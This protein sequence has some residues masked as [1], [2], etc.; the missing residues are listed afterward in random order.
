MATDQEI[1]NLRGELDR[2]KKILE[3]TNSSFS[4]YGNAIKSKTE[5]LNAQMRT[6]KTRLDQIKEQIKLQGESNIQLDEEIDQIEKRIKQNTK[7][8][9]GEDERQ[10]RNKE[11]KEALKKFT[12][13]MIMAA[14]ST[15]AMNNSVY[16]SEKAFSSVVPV[17]QMVGEAFKTVSAAIFSLGSAVPVFG[18]ISEQA[19]KIVGAAIT[20]ATQVAEM[21]IQ[22]AQKYVDTYNSLSK[23]GVT[24]GGAIE[25]M[26]ISATAAG[27][28]LD[29]YSK[30]ITHNIQ[31]LNLIG[32]SAEEGAASVTKF[33]R[34]LSQGNPKLLAMYGS[35]EDLMTGA[36][37]Y[38]ALLA[39]YGTSVNMS[40]A[41]L[42]K[43]AADYLYNMKELSALT[44]ESVDALKKQDEA[45]NR[46]AAFQL[47]LSGMNKEQIVNTNYAI[48]QIQSKY[49]EKVAAYAQEFIATNGHVTS[50]MALQ[51]Q[52]FF[53]Q[54]AKT[55][56]M[57]LQSTN[58]STNEF[59]KSNAELITA[60]STAINDEV[61]QRKSLAQ[62]QAG[63]GAG[64][65]IL[66]LMNSIMAPA[67]KSATAQTKTAEAQAH[68]ANEYQKATTSATQTYTQ[69]I[70]SLN[71]FKMK[72]D[73]QTEKS[74]PK[75]GEMV[76][77]LYK[78]N[79]IINEKIGKNLVEIVDNYA[80]PA[81]SRLADELD[82]VTHTQSEQDARDEYKKTYESA[83]VLKKV[84]MLP[85]LINNKLDE[86]DDAILPGSSHW[87]KS[88]PTEPTTKENAP[89]PPGPTASESQTTESAAT[90]NA[91]ANT[92]TQVGTVAG[93]ISDT[94]NP[95]NVVEP[96]TAPNAVM[97]DK[98]DKI[99]KAIIDLHRTSK[100]HKNTSEKILH[101]SS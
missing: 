95:T 39:T 33:T 91:T 3:T 40:N 84:T 93:T 71:N 29:S 74:L 49:G 19:G 9:K 27:L 14:G 65:E 78:V 24:F 2:L 48:D 88:N 53:P 5:M 26:R 61:K 67:L 75:V 34:G 81:I 72:I 12:P 60:R 30:F 23:V 59:R 73:E 13:A 52:S 25:K 87:W 70:N 11:Y 17:L 79:N 22:N 35:M 77:S 16:G 20:I 41:S 38:Q 66:E 80:V 18:G 10:Q 58:Q 63:G 8:I 43:G 47:A 101:A 94:Y 69:A 50:S 37:D 6:D 45:R 96:T 82:K 62:L 32:G 28:N 98:L 21:Q 55:V 57:S 89:V 42:S 86:W 76:E 83:P 56:Q 51:I 36:A 64:N 31:S 68:L 97:V 100:D 46:S 4:S 85:K 7:A 54:I 99:H 90:A 92:N 1:E 15:V 44:G